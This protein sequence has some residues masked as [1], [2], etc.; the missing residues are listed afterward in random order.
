MMD[1]DDFVLMVQEI[2]DK[3]QLQRML[4]ERQKTMERPRIG[5]MTGGLVVQEIKVIMK[6]ITKLP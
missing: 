6:R 4:E 1:I 3:D 2:T 5:M